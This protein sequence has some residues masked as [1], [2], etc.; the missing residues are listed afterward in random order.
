[1]ASPPVLVIHGGAGTI[2][3]A[4]ITPEKEAAFRAALAAV[5]AAGGAALAAGASALDVATDAVAAL[6]DDP[7]FN[8]GRG[9]VFAA[10]GAHELD[11]AVMVSDGARC[12]AVA[13]AARSRNPIRVARLVMERSAHVL[14][15]GE[16]A[17][18]FAE[19]QGCAM[20]ENAHFSTA[21]RAEQLAAARAAASTA[22]DHGG[23]EAK[24][25]TVGAVALDS[26]GGLAAATSTG[27][28]TNKAR[29]RVG[30]SP[31]VGAGTFCSPRVAVSCT[32]TGEAFLRLC[33]AKDLD[34]RMEYGGQSVGAA[35]AAVVG[36]L[37]GVG[38]QGGLIAVDAAGNVA[39]PF[40]SEGMYR[41][42][43][44]GGAPIVDIWEPSGV[45]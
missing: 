31:V 20:V 43:V 28:M 30:D 14:L 7:L 2:S 24:M 4:T 25:G 27:G 44:R 35:A 32:G 18:A 34:A 9:A 37:G 21:W 11:A 41:G 36:A 10:S 45:Y 26:A 19:A 8:A 5:L 42:L 22:L 17:D 16:G 15:A 3:R 33:A 29:G 13:C 12:G 6:E 23:G 1:M 39:A 40:N 38:G